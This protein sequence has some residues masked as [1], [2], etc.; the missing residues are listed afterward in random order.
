MSANP[1]RKGEREPLP[2]RRLGSFLGGSGL[3]SSTTSAF[4]FLSKDATADFAF[5]FCFL[6]PPEDL[7]FWPVEPARRWG[8]MLAEVL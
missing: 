4:L 7:F 8:G 6:A 3:S 1:G 2:F 5:G